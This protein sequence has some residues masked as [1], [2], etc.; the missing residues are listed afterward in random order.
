MFAGAFPHVCA[1]VSKHLVLSHLPLVWLKLYGVWME[2]QAS[3]ESQ[4]LATAEVR[5]LIRFCCG[6]LK[7]KKKKTTQTHTC[8][9]THRLAFQIHCI[10]FL[11][12]LSTLADACVCSLSASIAISLSLSPLSLLPNSLSLEKLSQFHCF[13]LGNTFHC[14]LS[15]CLPSLHFIIHPLV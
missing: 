14:F 10:S 5:L 4:L 13:S 12:Y 15:P 6:R 7:K 8:A 1:C 11:I 3:N 2:L 9:H